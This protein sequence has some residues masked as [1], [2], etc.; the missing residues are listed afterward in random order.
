M[1]RGGRLGA[2]DAIFSQRRGRIVLVPDRLECA[3]VFAAQHGGAVKIKVH[4]VVCTKP[5][6]TGISQRRAPVIVRRNVDGS[7]TLVIRRACRQSSTKITNKKT[8]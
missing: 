6:E 3:Q 7:T 4:H 8:P 2:I 5:R 1:Q